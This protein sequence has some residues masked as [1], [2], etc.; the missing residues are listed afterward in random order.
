MSDTKE[1][2]KSPE[3]ELN[4]MDE[5]EKN[6]KIPDAGFKIMVTRMLKGLRGRTGDLS[7]NLNI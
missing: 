3:K 2:Q 6:P 4:E 7:E 1:Q 5:M